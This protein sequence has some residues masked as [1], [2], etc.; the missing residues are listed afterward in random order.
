[1]SASCVAIKAP[2]T[3]RIE[4][5]RCFASV[6]DAW[7]AASASTR[8]LECYLNA[9]MVCGVVV[10]APRGTPPSGSL[11]ARNLRLYADVR[12]NWGRGRDAVGDGGRAARGVSAERLQLP[13]CSSRCAGQQRPTMKCLFGY[14][15]GSARD[16][17]PRPGSQRTSILVEFAQPSRWLLP[18]KSRRLW[19]VCARALYEKF[20]KYFSKIDALTPG[21]SHAQRSATPSN[22]SGGPLRCCHSW[23]KMWRYTCAVAV[24]RPGS[25]VPGPPHRICFPNAGAGAHRNTHG[26]FEEEPRRACC[27]ALVTA[28][29]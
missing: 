11:C 13:H 8:A 26:V 5:F 25:G 28:M 2:V 3:Q 19:Q 7:G 18:V 29:L 27:G 6:G 21:V 16:K 10:V 22:F 12:G 15:I 4:V 24:H 23:L 9:I 14:C 1:M 20:G 17:T